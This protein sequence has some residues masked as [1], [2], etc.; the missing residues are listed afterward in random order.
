MS[1]FWEDTKDIKISVT[2]TLSNFARRENLVGWVRATSQSNLPAIADEIVRLSKENAELRS[3]LAAQ[4]NQEDKINGLTFFET[5]TIL[6]ANQ[7]TDFLIQNRVALCADSFGFQSENA[8]D[9]KRAAELKLR[10][11]ITESHRASGFHIITEA[12]RSFLNKY[13][14]WQLTSEE[15]LCR[16]RTIRLPDI[17]II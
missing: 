17:N 8:N 10:G 16:I 12:G 6:D 11:L 5:K 9:R 2:E 7:L 3:Q 14:S 1:K 13:E 15:H 4:V